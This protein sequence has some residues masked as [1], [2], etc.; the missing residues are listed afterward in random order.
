[1]R[2]IIKIGQLT[3]EEFPLWV[4]TWE[5]PKRELG[6]SEITAGGSYVIF[7]QPLANTAV[8]IHSNSNDPISEG[9]KTSLEAMWQNYGQEVEI[10]DI[11]GNVHYAIFDYSRQLKFTPIFFGARI[12]HVEIPMIVKERV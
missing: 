7:V 5:A 11:D 2:K 12:Y 9:V 3:F 6:S 8:L 4:D 1:M 10:T